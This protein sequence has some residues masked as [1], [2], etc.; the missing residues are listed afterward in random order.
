MK[1][2]KVTDHAI[3]R[4]LEHTGQI[5]RQEIEDEIVTADAAAAARKGATRYLTPDGWTYRLDGYGA[6][7]TVHP[8]D[9]GK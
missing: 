2:V 4:Y 6:I 9:G 7:I 8:T 5:N 1:R 3:V